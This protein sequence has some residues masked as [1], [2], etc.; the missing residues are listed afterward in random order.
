MRKRVYLGIDS[1]YFS[2]FI[3][4]I[5]EYLFVTPSAVRM[6]VSQDVPLSCQCL[7]ALPTTEM[8]RV[9]V[10]G[11]CFCVLPGENELQYKER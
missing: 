1:N 3:T 7:I 5:G 4:C 10:L 11:H 6:V 2:T 8:T 9:P